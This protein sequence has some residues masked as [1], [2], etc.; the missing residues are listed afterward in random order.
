MDGKYFWPSS[1]ILVKLR[2]HKFICLR[3][4]LFT[5][6]CEQ[7]LASDLT[8]QREMMWNQIVTT[9]GIY[10][11]CNIWK[12]AFFRPCSAA[13]SVASGK[14]IDRHHHGPNNEK[15]YILPMIGPTKSSRQRNQSISFCVNFQDARCLRTMSFCS[16]RGLHQN[17]PENS[18]M[19]RQ[20]NTHRNVRMRHHS[21]KVSP[22][23]L[24]QSYDSLSNP[25][26]H[27]DQSHVGPVVNRSHSQTHL[28]DVEDAVNDSLMH[29]RQQMLKMKQNN[30]L[31]L[32]RI[33]RDILQQ[34]H[35]EILNT[36]QNILNFPARDRE[37][38]GVA[39][40]L[41]RRLESFTRN[42]DCR[43]CWLQKRHCVCDR[44]VPLEGRNS[45]GIP[46]VR[47][48]FLLVSVI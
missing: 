7:Q 20:M 1:V 13:F 27:H 6:H 48:L 17:P 36:H 46:N 30:H 44:C 2:G 10:N 25:S 23:T 28:D 33:H 21:A 14:I 47:R 39:S 18:L 5:Q 37:C 3:G 43:R 15:H 41:K 35:S 38:I 34:D 19:W 40:N 4:L 22:S 26:T 8:V 12:S 9:M 16:F 42:G 32:N 31:S 24:H 29:Y 11:I 45:E